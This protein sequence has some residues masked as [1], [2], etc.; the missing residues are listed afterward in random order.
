MIDLAIEL[1]DVAKRY[2]FFSLD[3]INLQVPRGLVL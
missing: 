1:R 2:P 3:G